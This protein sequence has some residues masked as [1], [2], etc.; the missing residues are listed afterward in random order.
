MKNLTLIF[1]FVG[2]LAFVGDAY[3]YQ[4]TYA[5]CT[6]ACKTYLNAVIG[7]CNTYCNTTCRNGCDELYGS[8]NYNN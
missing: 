8:V 1:G 4:Y 6:N 7:P 3:G 2:M 5:D